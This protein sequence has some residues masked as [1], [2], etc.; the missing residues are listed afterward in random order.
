MDL[1]IAD[2]T[3]VIKTASV[4]L[5]LD[6]NDTKALL[7]RCLAFEKLGL[8]ER[9]LKDASGLDTSNAITNKIITRLKSTKEKQ[10]PHDYHV[11]KDRGNVFYGAE[12]Y[13]LALEA[14]KETIG[15]QDLDVA[16]RAILHNNM[17][18]CY[19]KQSNYEAAVTEAT[20]ALSLIPDL[21]KALYRRCLAYEKLGLLEKALA[22]AS[23]LDPDSSTTKEVILRLEAMF[24]EHE[25]YVDRDG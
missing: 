19:L 18:Q 10:T 21:K 15:L 25:V 1:K 7:R 13:D 17:A 5:T 6:P 11:L 23:R 4:A 3:T 8:L 22:D 16:E 9:A 2:Y 14:Y 24:T 12:Q 20:S